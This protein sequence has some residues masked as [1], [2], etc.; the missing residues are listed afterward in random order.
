VR[1]VDWASRRQAIVTAQGV[2]CSVEEG[3]VI[4]R[5]ELLEDLA[6]RGSRST[7]AEVDSP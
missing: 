6:E 2:A 1:L 4:D 3:P 5:S 7:S